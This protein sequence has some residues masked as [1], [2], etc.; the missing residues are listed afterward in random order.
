MGRIRGTERREKGSKIAVRSADEIPVPQQ[1]PI[2][3]LRHLDGVYSIS[4][5]TKD[6][7]AAFADTL[8]RLSQLTWAQIYSSPRHGLGFEKIARDSICGSIPS[9]I[10]EDVNFIAFRF[11]GMAAMVGYQDKAVFHVIWL[12]RDFTLYKH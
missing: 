1:K 12:D 6:E 7:K 5:C 8:H 3:S 11:C 4:R 9:H 2:F 10:T